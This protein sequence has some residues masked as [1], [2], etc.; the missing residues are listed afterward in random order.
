M[1]VFYALLAVLALAGVGTIMYLAGGGGA[2]P[3]VTVPADLM[4]GQAAG[5]V[6]GSPD[7]KIEI[8]E[9]GDF[10]CPGCGEFAMVTE[11]DIIE[12][13]VNTGI[14]RFRYVDFPLIQLHPHALS[15]HVAA[16]CAD[17]QSKFWE[18][19]DRIFAGQLQ[20]STGYTSDPK[21]VFERYAKESGLQIESWGQCYEERRPLPRI[22]ANKAEG[23]R[24][25]VSGTPTI[26][27][28]NVMLRDNSSYDRIKFVLDSLLADSSSAAG[29]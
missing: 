20:W 12:R 28:G 14:A 10:E 4:P 26:L 3:V 2:V 7:A 18:M 9:F 19:H 23:E 8:T 22:M 5:Y 16:A 1:K 15:A 21:K 6:K 25:N 17:E 29:G 24:L 11:P 13:L 27:V